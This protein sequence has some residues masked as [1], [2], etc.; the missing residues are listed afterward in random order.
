M[1]ATDSE[2]SHRNGAQLAAILAAG[3]GA[4][5]MGAFVLMNEIG[6]LAAPSLYG[7]AGGVS[8]RTT[9]AVLAWLIAWGALHALW[10]NRHMEGRGVY[11]TTVALIALGIAACFPPLWGLFG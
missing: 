6:I 1:Q 7:P 2:H 4:F 9:F 11:V 8:G 3:V 10:R 5:A